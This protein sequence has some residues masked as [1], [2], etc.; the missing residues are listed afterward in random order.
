MS[1]PS[2]ESAKL[3]IADA[4]DAQVSEISDDIEIG[5]I[6][7]WDSLGHLRIIMA[8]EKEIGGELDANELVEIATLLDVAVILQKYES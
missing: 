2:L 8:I 3:L 7:A 5:G 1:E 4:L 6:D